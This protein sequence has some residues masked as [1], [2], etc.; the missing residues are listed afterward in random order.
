MEASAPFVHHLGVFASDFEASQRFY[1]AVLKPLGITARYRAGGVVEHWSP[2]RDTPSLSLERAENASATTRRIHIAV[3]AGSREAVN[4]FRAAAVMGIFENGRGR[5]SPPLAW[6]LN[7][8]RRVGIEEQ[9]SI[10]RM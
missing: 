6:P 4:A 2:E 3:T 7:C 1:T 9:S 5:S 8:V 10:T